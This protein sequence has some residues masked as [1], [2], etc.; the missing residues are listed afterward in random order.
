MSKELFGKALLGILAG[1]MASAIKEVEQEAE[2]G[3]VN[4][5]IEMFGRK[6]SGSERTALCGLIDFDK[7]HGTNQAEVFKESIKYAVAQEKA[8]QAEQAGNTNGDDHHGGLPKE[9]LELLSEKLGVPISDMR[10][11]N[12]GELNLS[13]I[14]GLDDE[15]EETHCPLCAG[16]EAKDHLLMKLKEHEEEAERIRALLNN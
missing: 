14:F 8:L 9:V 1:A 4:R 5:E 13:D 12:G 11:V 2:A 6:L 3:L 16:G 15:D 10:V 7:Q